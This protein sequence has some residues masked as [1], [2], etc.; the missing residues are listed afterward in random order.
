MRFNLQMD[1]E[2]LKIKY[3]KAI[4]ILDDLKVPKCVDCN[5]WTDSTS[6]NCA[7]CQNR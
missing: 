5:E 3:D 1:Y 7:S 4:K 2:Q 6:S